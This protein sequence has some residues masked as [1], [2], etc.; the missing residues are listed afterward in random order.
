MQHLVIVTLLVQLNFKTTGEKL[1]LLLLFFQSVY[2]M[3]SSEEPT[4]AIL[5]VNKYVVRFN[6]LLATILWCEV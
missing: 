3:T 4:R 2:R 5:N 1:R 6:K